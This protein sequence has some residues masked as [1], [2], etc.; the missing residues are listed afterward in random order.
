MFP[1][2]LLPNWPGNVMDTAALDVRPGD[3]DAIRATEAKMPRLPEELLMYIF[4]QYVTLQDLSSRE[5]MSGVYF[6][7]RSRSDVMKLL[8]VNRT[9][10][11]VALGTS[12]L[13]TS[14]YICNPTHRTLVV[15]RQWLAISLERIKILFLHAELKSSDAASLEDALGFLLHILQYTRSLKLDLSDCD[16]D[17][18]SEEYTGVI[19]FL[20]DQFT[21]HA[22]SPVELI[23]IRLSD[24][25]RTP[26]APYFAFLWIRLTSFP[27]IREINWDFKRISIPSNATS[28]P[29]GWQS[30]ALTH[31]D[32]RACEL[33][34][35]YAL[36]S[37][38]P[39]IEEV[40]MRQ[41]VFGTIHRINS[42]PILLHPKLQILALQTNSHDVLSIFSK[43]S[44]PNLHTLKLIYRPG[45][46]M[47]AAFAQFIE[48]SMPPLSSLTYHGMQ[49]RTAP[50]SSGPGVPTFDYFNRHNPAYLDIC[51]RLSTVK[52]IALWN[53]V[54]PD[55]LRS[56]MD[57]FPGGTGRHKLVP[58]VVCIDLCVDDI[59][60]NLVCDFIRSRSVVY[61]HGLHGGDMQRVI[62]RR[63]KP[64]NEEVEGNLRSMSE[65]GVY[66]SRE[67]LWPDFRRVEP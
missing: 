63:D 65:D 22:H 16:A 46:P 5:E 39:N 37:I 10:R 7:S 15:A 32:V 4:Q 53:E 43:L 62:L 2:G 14:V 23:D 13:W 28:Y 64:F 11:R 33:A 44:L 52:H 58:N 30:L 12:E 3:Y 36:L 42:Q 45:G 35:L 60:G 66:I 57:R 54:T 41:L 9:W 61:R 17:I 8:K 21:Q 19:Q 55:L 1:A 34:D 18:S 31:I 27:K 67:D 48:R 59:D 24:S 29:P 56:L 25:I 51:T 40:R 6:S 38:G 50:R 49:P 47:D 20:L 26:L